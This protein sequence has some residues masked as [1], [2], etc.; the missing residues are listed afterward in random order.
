MD[1]SY[2]FQTDPLTKEEEQYLKDHADM[3][4]KEQMSDPTFAKHLHNLCVEIWQSTKKALEQTKPGTW[5][6]ELAE[7]LLPHAE[8]LCRNFTRK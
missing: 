4:N 2:Q 8:A 7:E 3:S 5:Q 6:H 1:N